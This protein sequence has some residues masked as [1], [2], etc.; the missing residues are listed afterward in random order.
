MIRIT[1][2]KDKFRRC[3]VAHPAAPAEY[4]NERF[5]ADELEALLGEPMLVVVVL[6]DGDASSGDV[7][8]KPEK[9]AKK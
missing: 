1:A 2:G 7:G 8:D 9:A 5:T 3:G 6:P 4:P